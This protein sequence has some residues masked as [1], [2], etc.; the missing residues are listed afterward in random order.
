MKRFLPFG[1]I[2]LALIL[3]FP[4]LS[5]AIDRSMGSVDGVE[6]FNSYGTSL[7]QAVVTGWGMDVRRGDSEP[8]TIT[9]V[10]AELSEVVGELKT[11]VYREDV[12][13]IHGGYSYSG[14]H[15]PV[16]KRFSDGGS[17]TF[18][19]YTGGA[20]EAYWNY[21]IG[22]VTVWPYDNGL[23]GSF[24]RIQSNYAEGWAID[25][26]GEDVF[27]QETAIMI[28]IDGEQVAIG[29]TGQERKDVQDFWRSHDGKEI[30]KDHGF[31]VH[32]DVPQKFRDGEVH[33]FH[34]S[35]LEF[36]EGKMTT[37]GEPIY[38]RIETSGAIANQ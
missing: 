9:V 35:A 26:D 29:K 38:R 23:Q 16:P 32:I 10:N 30:G 13:N 6:Y 14:F 25:L 21:P 22:S 18:T 31:R 12:R 37:I 7:S 8:T 3:G 27:N 1:V 24:D 33:A 20:N 2:A 5:G 28:T 4:A 15:W 19:F 17:Y 36:T 11:D 34:A